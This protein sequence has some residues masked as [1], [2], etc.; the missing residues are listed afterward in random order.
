MSTSRTK[1]RENAMTIL[2]QINLYNKN[3]INYDIKDLIEKIEDDFTKEIVVNVISKQ[4]QLDEKANKYLNNWN[5]SRLGLT[6]AAILRVA[7][8]E[9]LYTDT[10]EKVVINEA[11][12]L[13]K[14]YSDDKVVKMINGTLDKIYHN[15]G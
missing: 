1:A 2:Y 13:S 11:I 7:I 4:N 8:Y 12:E 9:L 15:K 5:I 10:P 3:E 6:D 14:K